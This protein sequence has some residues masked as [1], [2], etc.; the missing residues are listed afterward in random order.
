ISC[1]IKGEQLSSA[2]GGIAPIDAWIE[3]WIFNDDQV[4]EAQNIVNAIISDHAAST[5]SR[6][7]PECAEEIDGS[8]SECWKCGKELD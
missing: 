4:E 3:V 7:C 2:I 8:F 5:E 1:T 6:K